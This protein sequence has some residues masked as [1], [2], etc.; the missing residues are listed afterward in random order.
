M[1][2]KNAKKR[3][4]TGERMS[5]GVLVFSFIGMAIVT[6]LTLLIARG[7]IIDQAVGKAENAL[8]AGAREVDMWLREKQATLITIGRDIIALDDRDA[9]LPLLTAQMDANGV[10]IYGGFADK[11][12]AFPHSED[13]VVP[14]GFDVTEE[15]WY[16]LGIDAKGEMVNW[17][18][19]KDTVS[20]EILTTIL[21][22]IGQVEGV[23]AV[24]GMDFTAE[25]M[26]AI[27]DSVETYDGGYVFLANN[28]G[29]IISHPDEH[30]A[31]LENGDA[32]SMLDDPVYAKLYDGIVLGGKN[33]LKLK[34]FDGKERYLIGHKLSSADWTVYV[35]VPTAVIT[36][37]LYSR[38]IY[39]A[40]AVVIMLAVTEL[41]MLNY[42]KKQLRFSLSRVVRAM[43]AL[44]EGNISFRVREKDR[45][46]DEIGALY[47]NFGKIFR[48]FT[49]LLSDM[50]EMSEQ[51]A[52]GNYQYKLDESG[53]TGAYL[54]I[55]KGVNEMTFT[56][57]NNFMELLD[58][59]GRFG[60]GDFGANVREYPGE[61]KIANTR[62]DVLRTNLTSVSAEV[63][64]LAQTALSGN[65]SA[66]ASETGFNGAWAEILINL[67]KLVEAVSVPLSEASEVLRK[68]S[69]GDLSV[70]MNGDYQGDFA[71]M[72]TSMNSTVKQLSSYISAIRDTLLN[73]SRKDTTKYILQP[74]VGEFGDIKSS[75]NKIVN[76]INNLAKTVSVSA[77]SVS[78]GA[79][80]IS[81]SSERLERGTSEQATA[82]DILKD[83]INNINTQTSHTA[84]NA[85]NAAD[86]SKLSTSSAI[87]GSTRVKD[88]LCSMNEIKKES[89]NISAVIKV[90]EDIAFQTNLLALNASVEAARAGVHGKGF[91]VVANEVRSLAERSRKAAVSTHGLIEVV[92][93]KIN[94]GTEI[95]DGA[96]SSLEK[97]VESVHSVSSI[98]SDISLASDEQAEAISQ[99]T[100]NIQKISDVVQTSYSN[101]QESAS[102]ASELSAQSDNLRVMLAE[103]KV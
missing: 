25:D 66:R 42:I 81:E 21:L 6:L 99:I 76:M 38:L 57:V 60:G 73:V 72:K 2:N 88:M 47:H 37:P 4:S 53:Y 68:M 100:N 77:R 20:G 92:V 52:L 84:E 79:S 17:P 95:A 97:I 48:R 90:I 40:I 30:F 85:K 13:Y 32:A 93:S 55:V 14:E 12:A 28:D 16:T 43:T 3:K 82:I 36:A 103:Y 83:K 61:L 74:F 22:Y 89:S 67:N 86:L 98:I 33:M 45:H 5:V 49:R 58:V 44:S 41:F 56:Y 7:I 23:D 70:E 62:I 19:E 80:R 59:M 87:D 29:R 1:E 75:I 50:K 46:M 8:T 35:A 9:V 18:P 31:P 51:H 94:N 65:L 71:L 69:E 78:D 15:L 54:D 24:L 26:T 101:A 10:D 27:L 64:K 96:S 39:V 91:A 102:A 63:N 34:D 11:T